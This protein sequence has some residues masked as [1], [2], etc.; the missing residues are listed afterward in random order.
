MDIERTFPPGVPQQGNHPLRLAKRVDTNDVAAFRKDVD[1]MKQAPDL[2]V[3]RRMAEDRQ[4]KGGLGHEDVA[5]HDLKGRTGGIRPPLVIAGDDN[6]PPTP[7]EDD[8]RRAQHVARRY[9][10]YPRLSQIDYLPVVEGVQ[11]AACP[12]PV[13]GLHDRE[14][15]RRCQN[16]PMAGPR[17]E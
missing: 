4:G 11:G 6:A 15:L 9:E 12:L 3:I 8:L 10:P 14:R 5:G 17:M 16:V 7:L 2:L 1:G 13:A